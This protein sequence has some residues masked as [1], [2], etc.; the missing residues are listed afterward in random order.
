MTY[1][2]PL[3]NIRHDS[4]L[5]ALL[6]QVSV[7]VAQQDEAIENI[8]VTG[9]RIEDDTRAGYVPVLTFPYFTLNSFFLCSL[10]QTEKAVE[11]ARSARRKRWICF[12][13]IVLVL[14]VLA[15][16]LGI[17]FGTKKH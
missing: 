12:S 15:I 3:R 10:Q 14:A 1:V 2:P 17:V 11:H 9:R 7:L 5:D 13:I 16:V 8:D 6:S 4:P